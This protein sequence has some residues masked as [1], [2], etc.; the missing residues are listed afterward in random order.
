MKKDDKKIKWKKM[1][2]IIL[3]LWIL[4][5]LIASMIGSEK[6]KLGNTAVIDIREE[7]RVL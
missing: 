2:M 7:S 6:L 4:S 3:G 1:I 5:F